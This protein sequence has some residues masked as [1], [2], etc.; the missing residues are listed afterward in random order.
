[1]I[2]D[3]QNYYNKK[4]SFQ[5]NIG[6]LFDTL[7]LFNIF[8]KDYILLP[9]YETNNFTKLY[10]FIEN[11]LFIRNIYGTNENNCFYVY[12]GFITIN[13]ILFNVMMMI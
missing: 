2:W 4:Y 6:R 13:I 5:S 7:L 1:M 11:T 3:I 10:E 12:L 8:K 9:S